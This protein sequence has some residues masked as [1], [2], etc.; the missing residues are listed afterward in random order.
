M[1]FFILYGSNFI[2][3]KTVFRRR[4]KLPNSRNL[5]KTYVHLSVSYHDHKVR[6]YRMPSTRWKSMIAR[7]RGIDGMVA[8]SRGDRYTTLRLH[9]VRPE[10]GQTTTGLPL[11]LTPMPRMAETEE[12]RPHSIVRRRAWMRSTKEVLGHTSFGLIM[13]LNGRPP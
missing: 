3:N 6:I 13:F 1:G 11:H 4:L 7:A 5:D 8:E 10:L 2:T 12:R 9:D